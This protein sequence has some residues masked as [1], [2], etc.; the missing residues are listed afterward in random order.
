MIRNFTI[1]CK[2]NL[3]PSSDLSLFQTAIADF[4]IHSAR[5]PFCGAKG[6]LSSHASYQ[7]DLISFHNRKVLRHILSIPRVIC[8]SC[9]H[10]HAVLPDVLIPY[11]SYSISFILTVLRDFSLHNTTVESLLSRYCISRSTLYSWRNL[12]F[13]HKKLWLGF[14]L[15]HSISSLSFLDALFPDSFLQSFFLKTGV[16]F[17]QSVSKTAHFHLP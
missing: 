11:G 17:L 15:D 3:L 7:R 6:C 4:S 12:F 16:S 2:L 10:T 14:L 13:L 1:L 9:T 8:S 5:C